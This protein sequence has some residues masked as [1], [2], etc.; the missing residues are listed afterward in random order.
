MKRTQSILLL[1]L[2]IFVTQLPAS[3]SIAATPKTGAKCSKMKQVQ[4]VNGLRY[5]CIKSAGG[6]VWSKGV[7][8]RTATSTPTPT[9]ICEIPPT[10]VKI[11]KPKIASLPKRVKS[12]Y[13][14]AIV[15]LLF[16]DTASDAIA[17]FPTGLD[18]QRQIL[19]KDSFVQSWLTD[20]SFG[21]FVLVGKV[22]D[23][24]SI[25]QNFLYPN[26]ETFKNDKDPI[27]IKIS[28]SYQGYDLLMFV[29]MNDKRLGGANSFT[30]AYKCNFRINGNLVPATQQML[31]M[32][33]R[34]GS[35]EFG[36]SQN[37]FLDQEETYT[38]ATEKEFEEKT[39]KT[40]YTYFQSTFLHEL[41]H[42]LGYGAHANSRTAD[43]K[44][45]TESL[46][47]SEKI[48]KEYGNL[49][50]VMG[51]GEYMLGLSSYIK[52]V[53]GWSD[54]FGNVAFGETKTFTL[55][56]NESKQGLIGI[57]M[58]N[59]DYQEALSPDE[60]LIFWGGG[61]WIEVLPKNSKYSSRL[62]FV[63]ANSEGIV[64]H[65]T[66]AISAWLL[67][68]SPNPIRK[69]N[70]GTAPDTSDVVLREGQSF[71]DGTISITNVKVQSTGQ[72]T[73]TVSK[74]K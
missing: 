50:D 28:E 2:L 35:D 13:R 60:K 37:S 47:S 16:K 36:N 4:V 46:P 72:V 24:V 42:T 66:E 10:S 18:I 57:R 21:S 52:Y 3:T 26:G 23:A 1:S 22:F 12:P 73:F 41:I 44:V 32:P 65:Q 17:K 61:Y 34:I 59:S 45:Y 6:L 31:W 49:F 51:S 7:T 62:D 39:R 40:S 56:H 74:Q 67:D 53:L 25:N 48:E 11:S 29:P 69:Y 30:T 5:T 55:S 58:V 68:A 70:W 19:D 63:E 54:R 27:D 14:V 8:F 15:P 20:Q 38:R 71:N 33:I 9:S 43:G 64:I